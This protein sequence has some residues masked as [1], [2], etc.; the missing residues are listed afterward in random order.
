MGATALWTMPFL[1]W[2]LEDP[3]AY[4]NWGLH[5]T[6]RE[7]LKSGGRAR[8]QPRDGRGRQPAGWAG[9][10]PHAAGLV[11]RPQLSSTTCA[12]P[13]LRLREGL[14]SKCRESHLQNWLTA[15]N[16]PMALGDTGEKCPGQAG[17]FRDS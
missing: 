16:S 9:E 11:D 10:D 8:T 3:L 5:I 7:Q 4:K 2:A 14:S 15:P 13:E 12:L 17:S 1:A 6:A